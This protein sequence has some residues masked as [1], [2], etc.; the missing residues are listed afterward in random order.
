VNEDTRFI[1]DTEFRS[2]LFNLALEREGSEAQ[3]GRRLGYQVAKGRRFRELR[4]GV[5]KSMSIHQLER[6]SKMTGI[7][8]EEI[9]KHV[10]P[11][12]RVKVGEV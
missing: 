5:I 10:I 3:V 4:D 2:K 11:R 7:S 9:L 6:L 12:T 1:L 8:L